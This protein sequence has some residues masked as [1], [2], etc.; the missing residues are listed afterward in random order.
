MQSFKLSGFEDLK[1]FIL[2]LQFVNEDIDVI[3]KTLHNTF[4]GMS[5]CMYLIAQIIF[6]R[7]WTALS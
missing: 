7:R 4:P 3:Q 6:C 2:T 5:A 1:D